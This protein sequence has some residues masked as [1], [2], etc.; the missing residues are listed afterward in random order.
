MTTISRKIVTAAIALGTVLA[1]APSAAAASD[2]TPPSVPQNVRDAS[3]LQSGNAVLVW[4]P[5]TDVGTG[6]TH[7]WVLVDG[8]QRARPSATTYDL[9]TLVN[10]GRITAGPHAVTVQAVDAA[11]NRSAPSAPVQVFVIG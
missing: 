7:Y 6:V 4:D 8:A 10:L 11:G 9:Q 2:T 5:S 1:V 3:L